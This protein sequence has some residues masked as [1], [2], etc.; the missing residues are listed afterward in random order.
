MPAVARS[1]FGSRA[2]GHIILRRRG[3]SAGILLYNPDDGVTRNF[4]PPLPLMTP[5]F[6]DAGR[7]VRLGARM[8]F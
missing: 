3:E 7:E 5:V 1:R 4:I 2:K 6:G 8:S